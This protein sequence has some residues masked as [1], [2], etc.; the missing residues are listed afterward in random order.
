M[1]YIQPGARALAQL[2]AND[3]AGL[4]HTREI[5]ATYNNHIPLHNPLLNAKEHPIAQE[6]FLNLFIKIEEWQQELDMAQKAMDAKTD[7]EIDALLRSLGSDTFHEHERK[8]EPERNMLE[9]NH[10]ARTKNVALF[11]KAFVAPAQTTFAELDQIVHSQQG[12]GY[13]AYVGEKRWQAFQTF[14]KEMNKQFTALAPKL[15]TYVAQYPDRSSEP[16]FFEQVTRWTSQLGRPNPRP[17]SFKPPEN[18]ERGH[19]VEHDEHGNP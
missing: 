11:S 6:E 9:R 19:D 13:Q 10:T 18:G 16:S 5:A 17:A 12:E 4:E 7:A 1:R 2:F 8:P 3:S 15:Q 14:I